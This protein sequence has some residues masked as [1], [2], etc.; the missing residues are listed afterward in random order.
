MVIIKFID[1]SLFESAFTSNSSGFNV[2]FS[3]PRQMEMICASKPYVSD[4]LN[5]GS[6]IYIYAP[7]LGGLEI[8]IASIPVLHEQIAHV[9]LI[10]LSTSARL[11]RALL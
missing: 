4:R 2:E 8:I 1:Q 9:H 10:T 11:K 6:A 3:C 7:Q 5:N